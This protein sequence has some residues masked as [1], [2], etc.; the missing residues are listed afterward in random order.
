MAWEERKFPWD[1]S[2]REALRIVDVGDLYFDYGQ[3][4][5]VPG[6]IEA[7]ALRI[8]QAGHSLV[9][10]GGDHFAT[11]PLLRA[12]HAVHGKLALVHFDAHC[13][14]WA[15]EDGR[16]D[17]GTM[18]YRAAKEGLIDATRS[19]QIGIRTTT[20]DDTLGMTIIDARSLLALTPA[21]VAERVRGVVGDALAVYV[22]F[23]IDCLDPSYAPG[24][25]TPVCGGPT[26]AYALEIVRA[27]R[28]LR[29]VAGDVM[30]VAPSYDS[31]QITALAG[32]T[33][34]Y[35]IMHLIAVA[36]G[37]APAAWP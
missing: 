2:V 33:I 17:H 32:A 5:G 10:L 4:S 27:L 16:V 25:G 3:P 26:T 11:Y 6:E 19:V 21:E 14:T 30:E 8:V 23:D 29:V 34:A 18:F 7:G 35:D 1:F 15:C 31:A 36:K 20:G 12:V 22:T 9:S 28:G 37:L 13:D 24:T